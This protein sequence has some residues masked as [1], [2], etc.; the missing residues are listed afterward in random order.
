M[1]CKCYCCKVVRSLKWATNLAN[2]CRKT[3]MV[4]KLIL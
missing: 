1:K 3:E 4:G 2:K